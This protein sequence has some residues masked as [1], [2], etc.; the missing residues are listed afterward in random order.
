MSRSSKGLSA[1]E[2]VGLVVLLAVIAG[3]TFFCAPGLTAVFAASRIFGFRLDVGQTW[4]FGVVASA[5]L[6]G[7]TWAATRVAGG[8]RSVLGW[9]SALCGLTVAA[10]ALSALGFHADWP[11]TLVSSLMR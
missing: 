10:G 2:S 8:E 6:Y 3:F 11:G 7:A 1:S 9:Y 4:A 5:F